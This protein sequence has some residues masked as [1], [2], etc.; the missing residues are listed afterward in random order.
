MQSVDDEIFAQLRQ[1]AQKRVDLLALQ[2]QGFFDVPVNNLYAEP[3]VLRSVTTL[4]RHEQKG[5][6]YSYA[7]STT[8]SLHP[9]VYFVH[10]SILREPGQERM[11][12]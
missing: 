2:I 10:D 11:K 8:V 12:A 9:A 3:S 5:Q 6:C 1:A 7:R 4:A